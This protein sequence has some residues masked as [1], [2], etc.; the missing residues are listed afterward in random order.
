[1]A[2]AR[3]GHELHDP[4]DGDA[5][6]ILQHSRTS[7][8]VARRSPSGRGRRRRGLTEGPIEQTAVSTGPRPP[9]RLVHI[10]RDYQESG[11]PQLRGER[12]VHDPQAAPRDARPQAGQPQP[13]PPPVQGPARWGRRAHRGDPAQAVQGPKGPDQG[14]ERGHRLRPP[15]EPA[16]DHLRPRR[17]DRPPLVRR[18]RRRPRLLGQ[19]R[20]DLRAP[21]R[22]QGR[23]GPRGR[24]HGPCGP[25]RHATSSPTRRPPGA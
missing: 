15:P 21:A 22:S 16:R 24:R 19:G 18:R 5:R 6:S 23:P 13:G 11:R 14:Q 7:D 20:E 4:G 10:A 8:G 3:L 12:P 1:M 17:D 25:L 2:L 9:R